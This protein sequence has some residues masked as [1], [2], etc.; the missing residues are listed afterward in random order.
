MVNPREWE[1]FAEE[2]GNPDRPFHSI[3]NSE[4]TLRMRSVP[5]SRMITVRLIEDAEGG[6]L[7]WI[8]TGKETVDMVQRRHIFPMQFVYGVEEEIQK[9]KGQVVNLRIEKIANLYP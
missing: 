5:T 8:Y 2:T 6:F 4:R 3:S 9:G 1:A 7:G